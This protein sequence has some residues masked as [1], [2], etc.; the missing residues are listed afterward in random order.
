MVGSSRFENSSKDFR[1]NELLASLRIISM[2]H[3]IKILPQVRLLAALSL[4][5]WV[6]KCCA[7]TYNCSHTNIIEEALSRATFTAKGVQKFVFGIRLQSQ[8]FVLKSGDF[9]EWYAWSNNKCADPNRP[10]PFS[11]ST[12]K[13]ASRK[14]GI[15]VAAQKKLSAYKS[16]GLPTVHGFCDSHQFTW[17]LLESA[18]PFQLPFLFQPSCEQ[19]FR[20]IE[21]P[22]LLF[23]EY[24]QLVLGSDVNANQ[25]AFTSDWRVVL[26]DLDIL[27]T[28]DHEAIY[29]GNKTA[30]TTFKDCMEPN[31]PISKSRRRLY[32]SCG[33]SCMEGSCVHAS[34][35]QR[36]TCILGKSVI[37]PLANHYPVLANVA[38]AASNDPTQRM[39]PTQFLHFIAAEKN[40]K[41]EQG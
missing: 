14:K 20:L 29:Y 9:G 4:L 11:Q 12:K 22:F 6:P 1:G 39:G 24:P 13:E 23:A 8:S 33:T 18:S 21:A 10:P 15:I 41:C 38:A 36:I 5:L 28:K 27:S 26:A 16:P 17:L 40:G 3:K 25:F 7:I 32:M 31:A 37:S 19:V 35:Q 2:H 30:C 34:T